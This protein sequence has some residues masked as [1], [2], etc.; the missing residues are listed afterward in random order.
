M[1]RP[2]VFDQTIASH[3]PT[4]RQA[5]QEIEAFLSQ[6]QV[7]E[8]SKGRFLGALYEAVANGIEHGNGNDPAKPL[9]IHV[10]VNGRGV[11]AT[12]TD[13]GAGFDPSAIPDPTAA[14]RLFQAR[15]RGVFLMK[16]LTDA[17]CFN[18]TGNAVTFTV[19][20]PGGGHDAG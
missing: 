13:G 18:P 11:T 16:S 4:A 19:R 2:K 17:L 7:G 9:T 1:R 8:G 15:G 6:M 14:E 3:R 20:E 10:S 12:V 5:L